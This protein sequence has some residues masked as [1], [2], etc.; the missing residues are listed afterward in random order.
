MK[1][2]SNVIDNNDIDE[3]QASAVQVG[4][5]ITYISATVGYFELNGIYNHSNNFEFNINLNHRW[6]HSLN[7]RASRIS[8]K[9]SILRS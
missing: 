9:S 6:N 2:H 8:K 7:A 4:T 5:L 1:Q 3:A